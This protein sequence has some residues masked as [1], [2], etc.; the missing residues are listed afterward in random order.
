LASKDE[1]IAHYILALCFFLLSGTK[2]ITGWPATISGVV[3][4]IEIVSAILWYSPINELIK[5]WR[6][7]V[8]IKIEE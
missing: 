6:E 7:E 4:T 8:R 5:Y 3:G 2:L 1:V